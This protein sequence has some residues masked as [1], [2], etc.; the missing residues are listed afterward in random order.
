MYI[1]MEVY[2]KDKNKKVL[3]SLMEQLLLS[4]TI[5]KALKNYNDTEPE[6]KDLIASIEKINAQFNLIASVKVAM[7]KDEEI[8][9]NSVSITDEE[10]KA[11]AESVKTLRSSMIN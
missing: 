11:I 2:L 5:I 4:E 1:A 6:L 7:E 3:G 8:D 10:L 9:F